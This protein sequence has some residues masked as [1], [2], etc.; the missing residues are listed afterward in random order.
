MSLENRVALITGA[1]RGI[2]R[3][4]ALAYAKEGARLALAARTLS[5]LEE[6]AQEAETLGAATCVIRTDVTVQTEVD[7]MVRQTLGRFAAIDV[8]VNNA[9][10]AGPVGA[11]Q[12]SDA[13]SWVHIIQVNLIGTYLCCRA[14]LPVMLRQDQGKIIN[15]SGAGA[16]SAWRHLSAY[17]ASKAAVVRLTEALSLELAG[18]SI[19]VNALGPGSTHTRMWEELRDGF[20]KAG[21]T[22]MY[23]LGQRVTS[24]GGASIERVAE[25]AVFLGSDVSGN[26]SGRLVSPG[27]APWSVYM[28]AG[29]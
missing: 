17:V 22:E 28:E 29:R 11:L 27:P 3:A 13:S 12:D 21:N 2:G 1:G 16:T 5:E 23:E 20:H 6:T 18:T 25:V 26:F 10:I 4:I 9:G 15:L 7:E 19:R 24:G 14:V 8:L